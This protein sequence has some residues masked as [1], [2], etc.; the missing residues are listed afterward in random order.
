VKESMNF[1]SKSMQGKKE[2]H[3]FVSPQKHLM[4]RE[5]G[6]EGFE[7]RNFVYRW[8]R[9]KKGRVSLIVA[10]VVKTGGKKR[11]KTGSQGAC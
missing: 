1:D 9:G 8:K 3:R 7:K 6:R 11:Y 4:F 10:S 5:A 2:K